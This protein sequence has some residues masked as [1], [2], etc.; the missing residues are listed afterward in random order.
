MWHEKV[1]N[2]YYK[3]IFFSSKEKNFSSFYEQ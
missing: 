1:V 3:Q 2:Y